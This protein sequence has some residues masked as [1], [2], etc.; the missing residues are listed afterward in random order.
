MRFSTSLLL[1]LPLL[2]A[3]AESPFEQYKAQFQNFLNSFGSVGGKP[4]KPDEPAAKASSKPS[5][6]PSA[7]GVSKKMAILTLENWKDTLYAP[8]KDAT[9]P[10]EW[11][12]LIT[13]RNKTCFGHC[14]KVEAAFNETATKFATLPNTPH[15]ALINCDDQRVLC[16]SWSCATGNLWIVD[17]L[18]PPAPVDIYKK[19]L[20]LTS[21]TTKDLVELQAA[22]AK[23]RADLKPM[24]SFFHPFDGPLAKY[25][26]S[27]YAG[28][29]LYFFNLVP[30]WLF[31][32]V[33][34]FVSR[35]L[36]SRRMD[37]HM[38][39]GAAPATGTAPAAPAPAAG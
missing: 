32:L 11:W 29:F 10:E 20:N 4:S 5:S 25:G 15:L 27:L 39:R 14:E 1:A 8:V 2:A 34:S 38:N 19:R 7:K 31:M 12:I 26:L 16:S 13:G 24:E 28:Y 9:K 35:T 17:M 33:V 23:A 21:T 18:P 6:K 3:A 37:N 36:M 22:G 30:N